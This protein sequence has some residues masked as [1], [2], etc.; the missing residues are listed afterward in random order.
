[1]TQQYLTILERGETSWGAYAPDVPGC[2]AAADTREAVWEMFRD[3]LQGHLDWM[4]EDGDRIPPP[5]AQ[6]E[7]VTVV[8]PGQTPRDY[9]AVLQPIPQGGWSAFAADVPDLTLE[10]PDRE[11]ALRLLQAALQSHWEDQHAKGEPLPEPRSEVAT[12]AVRLAE[13]PVA[14]PGRTL[15]KTPWTRMLDLTYGWYQ[16]VEAEESREEEPLADERLP[17]QELFDLYQTTGGLAFEEPEDSSRPEHVD[18]EI[19]AFVNEQILPLLL[20]R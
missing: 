14:A 12:V 19:R 18:E 8:R 13:P 9:P 15:I 5:Q 20:R 6:T 16:F 4:Q 11:G 17:A 1:M 3:S 10:F 7:C 2:T